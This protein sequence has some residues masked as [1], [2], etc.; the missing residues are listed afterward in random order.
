MLFRPP[1]GARND[2]VLEAAS[3]LG[4]KTILWNV[5]SMD[6]A[7]PV[8]QSIASRVIAQVERQKHGIILFHDIHERTTQ[9]LP[10]SLETSAWSAE[11]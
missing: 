6:W 8:P 5:D 1:Y 11:P 7:D 9:A 4:M 10:A 3:A 2:K